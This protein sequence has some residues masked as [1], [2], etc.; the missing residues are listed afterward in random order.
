MRGVKNKSDSDCSELEPEAKKCKTEESPPEAKT[1]LTE[2]LESDEKSTTTATPDSSFNLPTPQPSEQAPRFVKPP[3][4]PSPEPSYPSLLNLSDDVLLHIL[5]FIGPSDLVSLAHCSERLNNIARDKS[6]W[7]VCDLRPRILSLNRLHN[8]LHWLQPV[9][10]SFASCGPLE[11]MPPLK[12]GE[13]IE[14]TWLL[15][16]MILL[17]KYAPNLKT[18]VLENHIIDCNK[19]LIEDFPPSVENLSLKSCIFKNVP[20]QSSYFLGIHS[21]MSRL[22]ALDLTDSSWFVPHSLLALSKCAVLEELV[23]DGCDVS[24][25]MPYASLAAN[26]GFCNLRLLDLRNTAVSDVEV[27]CFNKM[28]TLR[29]LYI[30][31]SEEVQPLRLPY[32]FSYVTDLSITAFGESPAVHRQVLGRQVQVVGRPPCLIETLLLNN[33]PGITDLTLRHVVVAMPHLKL[34][35]LT[36]TGVTSEGLAKFKTDRPSVTLVVSPNMI[37]SEA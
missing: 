8:V 34:L 4:S 35:D 24:E 3:R 29:H 36:N 19:I 13:T 11:I 20:K 27:S 32:S 28:K 17:S 14:P 10:L 12:E 7:R 16:F 33:Y 37:P 1:I 30:S 18:L 26:Y 25:C 23:L 6:L 22:R 21:S 15:S 2:E 5:S 9:T 31:A